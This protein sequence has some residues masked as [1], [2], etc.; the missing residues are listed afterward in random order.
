MKGSEVA[1]AIAGEH[2]AF[3]VRMVR[4]RIRYGPLEASALLLR[5]KAEG[6]AP[7]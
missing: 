6:R 4:L 3:L 2:A 1:E 7:R 5:E